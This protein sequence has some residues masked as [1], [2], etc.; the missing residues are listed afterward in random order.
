VCTFVAEEVLLLYFVSN[1]NLAKSA[2]FWARAPPNAI[3]WFLTV[4]IV[5]NGY[6]KKL[7]PFHVVQYLKLTVD[8]K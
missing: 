6:F 7:T 4:N 1:G 5:Q 8:K 3:R 2:K